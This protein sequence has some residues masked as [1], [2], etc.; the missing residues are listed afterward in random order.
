MLTSKVATSI[1]NFFSVRFNRG[2][3]HVEF[4]STILEG[5]EGSGW[6]QQYPIPHKGDY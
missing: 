5:Y 1:R 2:G 3:V 6:S 4:R